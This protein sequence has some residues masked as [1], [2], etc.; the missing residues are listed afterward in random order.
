MKKFIYLVSTLAVAGLMLASC[1]KDD[2]N[3]VDTKNYGPISV[4]A[5]YYNYISSSTKEAV[6]TQIDPEEGARLGTM[7]RLEGKNFKG[8]K[9][10]VCN[11]STAYI[12]PNLLTETSVVFR[13]PSTNSTTNQTTPTGSD[14][15]E[16]YRDIIWIYSNGND[17]YPYYFHIKGSVPTVT[18][19]SHTIP[20]IGSWVTV[21]GTTL[22]DVEKVYFYNDLD[23]SVAETTEI[24]Q[25][26]D[27]TSFQFCMPEMPEDYEGGYLIVETPSGIAASPNYFWR[28]KLIFLSKFYSEPDDGL[29][30]KNP[31]AVKTSYYAWGSGTSGNMPDSEEYPEIT[32]PWP[33]EGDGPKNPSVFRAMP[34]P[35]ATIPFLNS[36]MVNIQPM[37]V[38]VPLVLAS[39]AMLALAVLSVLLRALI[40]V[41]S[42]SMRLLLWR[43]WH[44]SLTT[45]SRMVIGIAVV[46]QSLM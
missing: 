7:I 28:S 45:T 11:G 8:I 15:D 3:G 33:A 44:S 16:E 40:A 17:P 22:K 39:T 18:G 25:G 10:I 41:L 32:D 5:A 4:T 35:V 30:A 14:C 23:E 13:I 34:Y 42:S 21:T 31:Y 36:A 12:N 43:I 24:R 37:V 2:N 26:E 19:I 20:T 1:S 9:K 29:Y 27:G 46:S 6:L 38:L